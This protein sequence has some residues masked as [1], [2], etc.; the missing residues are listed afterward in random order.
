[1]KAKLILAFILISLASLFAGFFI[2]KL[3]HS[4]KG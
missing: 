4:G 2:G 1:M 3:I